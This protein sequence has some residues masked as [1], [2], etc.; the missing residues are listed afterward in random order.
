MDYPQIITPGA[1]CDNCRHSKNAI[2]TSVETIVKCGLYGVYNS[3][4]QAQHCVN[5]AGWRKDPRPLQYT[6]TGEA[7]PVNEPDPDSPT[8]AWVEGWN[9]CMHGGLSA[10][11]YELGDQEYRDWQEGWEAAE[12][13]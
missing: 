1:L 13:D 3:N 4:T 12:R 5:H 6:I 2:K 8:A 7:V 9:A 11:P 10:N